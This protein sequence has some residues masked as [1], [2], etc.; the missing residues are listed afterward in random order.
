MAD[1]TANIDGGLTL[2]QTEAR[3]VVEQDGGFQLLTI[4]FGTIIAE[5]KVLE[6]NKAEFVSKPIGRLNILSFV[7]ATND[8][9]KVKDQKTKDGFTLICES[10]IFVENHVKAVIVFGKKS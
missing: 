8:P 5:G 6:V 7:E 10:Q 2:S 3:C 1:L 9:Q 4:K